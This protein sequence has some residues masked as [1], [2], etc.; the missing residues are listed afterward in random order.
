MPGN[1]F[2]FL[3]KHGSYGD[4]LAAVGLAEMISTVSHV[5]DV[6]IED[7]G[8]YFTCTTEEEIDLI[9]V[10][11]NK[12]V[13]YP[14]FDY[15]QFNEKDPKAPPEAYP[16]YKEKE[17]YQV[18]KEQ[19]KKSRNKVAALISDE[20]IQAD[21]VS[22]DYLLMQSLRML[23][24]LD[25]S[26]KFY[27][28]I[29]KAKKED[30]QKTIQ[31]RLEM[32]SK[33]EQKEIKKEPFK[34]SVSA[35]QAYNPVVGKGVN[36]AKANSISVA[37]ISNKFVDW[38]EEWLRFIG[39]KI[40]LN[41]Y[42]IEKDL[43]FAAIVPQKA[44]IRTI[45]DLRQKFLSL[46][47][48]TSSKNDIIVSLGLT[49]FLVENS[50]AF[51][52]LF[53]DDSFFS[54]LPS[55]I[56]SGLSTAYFKSLG[57]G[58]A[59]I[60]NS[61]ISFPKWF[62]IVDESDA[63]LWIDVIEDHENVI[64]SLDERKSEEMELLLDYRNFLSGGGWRNFLSYLSSYGTLYM[65]RKD[66]GK[67]VV[68]HSLSIFERMCKRV[69]SI[70]GEVMA[71]EGFKEIAKAMREATVNEQYR[72]SRNQQQFEIH[73]GLFQEIKREAKFKDQ[74]INPIS[75]FISEYNMETV[76][77]MEQKG[78]EYKGRRLISYEA[79]EQLVQLFKNYPEKSETIA[80]LLIAAASCY[81]G[82]KKEKGGNER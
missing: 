66:A 56:I 15:V 34:V 59:L 82:K 26:N 39:S 11:V 37:T 55:D 7:H 12:L 8:A 41:A 65:R 80:L 16:Y 1:I 70:Y 3:K 35:V 79:F 48:F 38:F 25:T 51:K 33:L 22:D 69:G 49:K 28:A 5:D 29:E 72:K 62:P 77:K 76:R 19:K 40:I 78:A 57:S 20:E 46:R 68:Q 61:F 31:L 23:Q 71:N 54:Y 47:T 36:K 13:Q 64:R 63:D 53:N 24:A 52:R 81:D 45:K 9:K 74:V 67:F 73:Y 60:N 18:E 2:Y 17:L 14:C 75:K 32:Y 10:D 43:K 42:K 30:L 6:I 27:K 50:E 44:N 21:S 4:A 58:R